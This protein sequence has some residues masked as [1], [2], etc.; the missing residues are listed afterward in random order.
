MGSWFHGLI[1]H[2]NVLHSRND[3]GVLLLLV[4]AAWFHQQ[5]ERPCSE[6]QQS[7]RFHLNMSNSKEHRHLKRDCHFV[8]SVQVGVIYSR[9]GQSLFPGLPGFHTSSLLYFC[10]LRSYC[11]QL[12]DFL[13]FW[14]PSLSWRR[15]HSMGLQIQEGKI[16]PEHWTEYITPE[17]EN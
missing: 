13:P 14:S 3:P 9:P 17:W 16:N 1:S 4:C 7:Q 8:I 11:E 10:D 2:E 15:A 5:I 12:E 6:S